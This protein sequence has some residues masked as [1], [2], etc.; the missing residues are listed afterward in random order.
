MKAPAKPGRD[1]TPPET[2]PGQTCWATAKYVHHYR[3]MKNAAAY[4]E[5][6]AET[7]DGLPH[8]HQF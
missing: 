4:A 3:Y 8:P 2:S 1:D 6:A 7:A 5:Q